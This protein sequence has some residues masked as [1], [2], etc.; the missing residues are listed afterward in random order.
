MD[1]LIFELQKAY[2]KDAEFRDGQEKAIL[3]VL[4]GKRTLVV[5]KT[6]WGKSLVYF[7]STKMLRK[8]NCNGF[9]LIISPL[10]ALMNNQVESAKKLGLHVETINSDNKDNWLKIWDEIDRNTVD[11]LIISPERLSN[12]EFKS[13]LSKKFAKRIFLFVVDEAH[14]ISDWGHDFRPDYRRII[15]IVNML[16]SNIPVLATTATA[17]ERVVNDIKHQLGEDILI[18]RGHLMRESLI[19]QVIKIPTKEERLA[20]ILENLSRMEG[21]GI[22]Y[23]LTVSDCKLV[24]KWL[25]TNGIDSEAYYS[26]IDKLENKN[27]S[28]IIDKF[29]KNEIKV[30]IATVAFGMGFD[31][32]DIGFVIHFQ[33]PANLVSYYQQIGRAGRAISKANAILLVG[34]EDDEINHYFIESAFPTENLMNDVVE[35][36][37]R[38]PGSTVP[39]LT[40]YINMR[41]GKIKD[42]IKYLDVNGDIYSEQGKYYKTPKLWKPDL[43]KSGEITRLRYEELTQMNKYIKT[44]SC[45]MEYIAKALDDTLP[46]KCGKCSNCLHTLIFPEKVMQKNVIAAQQFVRKDFNVI[47]PRKKWPD[48]VKIDNENKIPVDF[49][50]EQGRVLSNYGDAG[51]GKLVS[52]GKYR[53]DY[54]DNQLVDASYDLLK[55]FVV[56]NNIKWITNVSSVRNPN[57][58]K[59]FTER[60]ADKLGLPYKDVIEKKA[61]YRCQKEFNNN[62]SQYN[63]AFASFEVLYPL[64]ENVL[65]VDDMV[66]SRWT[67]TVCGY[68]LRK[69]GCGK[70]Y[71]YALANS[72]A[73]NGDE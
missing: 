13:Q 8:Q 31:K 18:S 64:N 19:I 1:D 62:Y 52:E 36:I 43:I 17:N 22:I 14:C 30:L 40:T 60:L 12:D 24:N 47:E 37:R 63:N 9:T 35:Y 21:T 23:C 15:D 26:N 70:V 7:L 16:P 27:K 3:G 65:L 51:W 29:M 57:L 6:G 49:I 10:L 69:K 68:K 71:P 56:E 32:P 28:Q 45:Y 66:D 54:F 46:Q 41:S 42:C 11:A 20:W 4:S 55:D 38:Y 59:S 25:N 50:C 53:K 72:A 58:V 2:G 33:K 5:Q 61:G 48:Y 67:F 44:K 34:N 39:K 73:R